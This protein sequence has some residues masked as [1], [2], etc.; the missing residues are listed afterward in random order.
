MAKLELTAVELVGVRNIAE[1]RRIEFMPAK[2]IKPQPS[3]IP[4]SIEGHCKSYWGNYCAV[5][6]WEIKEL[7]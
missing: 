3:L 5:C 6:G 4:C 1:L 7:A 2:Y